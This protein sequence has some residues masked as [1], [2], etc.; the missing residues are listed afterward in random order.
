MEF[1]ICSS[2]TYTGGIFKSCIRWK[3]RAETSQRLDFLTA[4]VTGVVR[5]NRK[6]VR[7]LESVPVELPVEES[8]ETVYRCVIPRNALPSMQLKSLEVIY[9]IT[10]E[11]Y[12]GAM[13][14][15]ETRVFGVHPVG[16]E[17]SKKMEGIVVHA[18]MIRVG[19]GDGTAFGEIV[20]R[21]RNGFECSD[22]TIEEMARQ[23]MHLLEDFPRTMNETVERYKL[24]NK[25][26]IYFYVSMEGSAVENG[27]HRVVARSA[28]KDIAR[29][30]Y[31][32]YLV[33][34][35]VMV[36][37]YERNAKSTKITLKITEYINGEVAHDEERVLKEFNSDMCLYKTVPLKIEEDCFTF[38][39]MLFS[40]RFLYKVELDGLTFVLPINK[41]SPKA[42]INIDQL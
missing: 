6:E 35:E 10:V 12:Y 5:I 36:I 7:F 28:E 30:E 14:E 16:F 18:D 27:R 29:I 13:K 31:G 42:K 22:G 2:D 40:I 19:D 21:L 1:E 20:G 39:C 3:R 25:G 23:K 38:D 17:P 15:I 37:R 11:A 26:D 41:A 34:D 9:M 8:Q 24:E 33:K 4:R 32:L